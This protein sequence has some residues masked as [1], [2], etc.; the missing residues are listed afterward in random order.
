MAYFPGIFRHHT[1]RI[2]NDWQK[3]IR[4]D[5]AGLNSDGFKMYYGFS[6]FI[7]FARGYTAMY[8]DE[9]YTLRTDYIMPVWYPD[10]SLGSLA[11]FKRIT[12]NLFYDLS[13][14]SYKLHKD[15]VSFEYDKS[16]QSTGVEIRADVHPL[17]F[18]FPFNIGYRYSYRISDDSS[19][20][21][22]LFSINF[23]GY[24]VN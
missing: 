15:P 17:R 20:H 24:A 5:F 19:V 11:Y 3:K 14:Y 2:I 22:F 8:N 21:E 1:I 23:S 16:V 12:T 9:L 13:R 6:D 7:K 18:I 10:L 4:G